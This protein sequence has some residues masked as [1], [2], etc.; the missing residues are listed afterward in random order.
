MVFP[1]DP[2]P[3]KQPR[4]PGNDERLSS[5]TT[6]NSGFEDVRRRLLLLAN[7]EQCHDNVGGVIYTKLWVVIAPDGFLNYIDILCKQQQQGDEHPT[8]TKSANA[9]PGLLWEMKVKFARSREF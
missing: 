5:L 4:N 9:C 1:P 6:P 2:P 7:K 3:T 8:T